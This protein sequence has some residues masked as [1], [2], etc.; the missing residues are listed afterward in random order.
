[1]P[2]TTPVADPIDA[3]E[4]LLLVHVPPASALDNVVL[5]ATHTVITPVIAAGPE[6]TV[7]TVV[8]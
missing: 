4:V 8:A 7:T 2:V 3:T 6:V 1:L 5:S